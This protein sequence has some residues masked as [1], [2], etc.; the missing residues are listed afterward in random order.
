MIGSYLLRDLISSGHK[1]IGVDNLSRGKL[2]HI[3][4]VNGFNLEKDFMKADLS[5]IESCEE[6]FARL[7]KGDV[8]IHLADVVAGLGYVFDNEHHIFRE[9]N[10]INSNIVTLSRRIAPCRFIY[11]GT[12]CSFP[13]SLQLGSKSVM[14]EE[15][16]FPAEPESSY[17][18]SKLIGSLEMKYAFKKSN[19]IFTTLILHNVYGRYTDYSIQT[20]QVIP[21][22]IHKALLLKSGEHLKV[23][24]DGSQSRSFIHASDVSS[25]LV[26][27]INYPNTL[28]EYIQIGPNQA[29]T[30]SDLAKEILRLCGIELKPQFDSS[31][32]MGDLGRACDYSVAQSIL[33]WTPSTSLRDGLQ[34]L[35]TWIKP[36]LN[37]SKSNP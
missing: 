9:N 31:A 32:P 1:V 23:W 33:E 6:I 8:I 5:S 25:A 35:I 26:K 14:R 3:K 4:G 12:A 20:G 24:G 27:V 19:I 30:I 7:T 21:S 10:I 34:D 37:Q 2:D 15:M 28:P 36:R 17:G 18:W 29:T 22:L 13:K 16:L 11:V